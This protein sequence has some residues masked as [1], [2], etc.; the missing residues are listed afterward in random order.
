MNMQTLE[1]SFH[2]TSIRIRT[3]VSW[4]EICYEIYHIRR[5]PCRYHSKA[6][7]NLLALH[8]RIKNRL[9]GMAD[10]KCGTVR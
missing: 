9:C 1:N 8:R 2:N 10:C 3:T 5:N 6:D 7:K 4:D